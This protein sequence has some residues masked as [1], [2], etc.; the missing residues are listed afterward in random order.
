MS[1]SGSIC[2]SIRWIAG[3]SQSQ[4]TAADWRLA[5]SERMQVVSAAVNNGQRFSVSTKKQQTFSFSSKFSI[6]FFGCFFLDRN[7]SEESKKKKKENRE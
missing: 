6:I 1:F 3:K 7:P 2:L 5:R 4:Q